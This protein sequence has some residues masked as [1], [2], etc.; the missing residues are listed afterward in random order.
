[1]GVVGG[2]W[3]GP[4]RAV[5]PPFLSP[6]PTIS[7][8][9][10]PLPRPGGVGRGLFTPMAMTVCFALLGSLL[11]SLPLVPAVATLLFRGRRPAPRHRVLE[12]L[13]ERYARLVARAVGHARITVAL[14][15]ASVAASFWLAA[16]LG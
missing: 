3:R 4:A 9:S 14:A 2:G 6:L 16:R 12:W 5:R 11:L 8:G 10:T 15:V 7:A 1:G 13:T